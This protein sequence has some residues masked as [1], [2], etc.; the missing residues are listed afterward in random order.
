MAIQRQFDLISLQ[1]N[2]AIIAAEM[3]KITPDSFMLGSVDDSVK[4]FL[5]KMKSGELP[6]SIIKL[7]ISGDDLK[8]LGLVDKEIGDALKKLFELVLTASLYN[9]KEDLLKYIKYEIQCKNVQSLLSS[10]HTLQLLID[11][12][13]SEIKRLQTLIGKETSDLENVDFQLKLLK[14][15]Y[16][17]YKNQY[18]EHFKLTFIK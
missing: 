3:I 6:E 13:E 15:C 7:D 2:P 10:K 5:D 11:F 4:L 17:Y 9:K 1:V 14:K 18:N 16:L 12:Q 8:E